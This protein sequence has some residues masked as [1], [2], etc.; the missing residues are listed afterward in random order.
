MDQS[1]ILDIE[2]FR[3]ISK[4]GEGSYGIAYLVEESATKKRYVAKESKV[5]CQSSQEQRKFFNE[6]IASSKVHNPAVL[7]LLGL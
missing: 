2:N 1:L 3:I 5:E 4:I 6:I 7:S